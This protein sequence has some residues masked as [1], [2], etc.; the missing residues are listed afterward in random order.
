VVVTQCSFKIA[1]SEDK[2][3]LTRPKNGHQDLY[4]K[5]NVAYTFIL[6]K[7]VAYTFI[8]LSGMPGIP[9]LT[10]FMTFK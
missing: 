4:K 6:H 2:Y 9:F 3:V 5:K 10:V 8:L 7:N 1:E